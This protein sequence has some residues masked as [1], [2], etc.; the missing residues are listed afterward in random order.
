MTVLNSHL[1][2]HLNYSSPLLISASCA[3]LDEMQKVLSRN[4]KIVGLS[5][6]NALAK[7]GIGT[8]REYIEHT[9]TNTIRRMIHNPDHPVS[10]KLAFVPTRSTRG[11]F[12]F[13]LPIAR[14]EK[15]N[16]SIVP[17]CVR[18]L[19]DGDAALYNPFAKRK[20]EKRRMRNKRIGKAASPKQQAACKHCGKLNEA[21]RG[22]R[23][24]EARCK[25]NPL[26]KQSKKTKST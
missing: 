13:R 21:S 11:T 23:I 15:Y 18:L 12:N 24:H 10:R 16:N 2:S 3:E 19:R 26:A 6:E 5:E 7:Y 25:S 8:V 14:T 20:I 1:M 9:C 17:W 22:V 4:L